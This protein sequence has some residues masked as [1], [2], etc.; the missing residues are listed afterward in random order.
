MPATHSQPTFLTD[1]IKTSRDMWSKGWAEA[2]AGNISYRLAPEAVKDNAV[3]FRPGEWIPL[4][5]EVP[6][7]A[8]EAFL[9]TGSGRF[10]RNIELHPDKNLGAIEIDSAGKRYRILWGFKPAGAPTSELSAHLLA[11]AVRKE[12]GGGSDR[13]VIHTHAPNVIALSNALDLDTG[14]LTRLLWQIHAECIVMLPDGVE[15]IPWM[16]PGSDELARATAE[17]FS[18][19]KVVVWQFHGILAAGRNLDAAFGLIDVVEK[20]VAIYA[21]AVAAGGVKNKLSIEQLKLL[22]AKFN[23]HPDEKILSGK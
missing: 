16:L 1:I 12:V 3:F 23:V 22:A 8:G 21:R 14:T 11:Q 20:A 2:N 6:A 7:L 13:G 15:F 10:L 4:S 19:R 9:V 5:V 17:A 18:R